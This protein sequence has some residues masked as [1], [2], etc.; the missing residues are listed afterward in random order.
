M[1]V[2]ARVHVGYKSIFKSLYDQL[3]DRVGQ[4]FEVLS[5]V[6][7]DTKEVDV[8]SVGIM[9]WIVFNDGFTCFA[10]PEEVE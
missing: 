7:S 8:T 5:V 3:Q 10:W 1:S 4:E 9:Y 6:D 2:S